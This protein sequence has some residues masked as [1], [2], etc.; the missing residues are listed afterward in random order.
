MVNG[1]LLL[2]LAGREYFAVFALLA[3]TMK[4]LFILDK[5]ATRNIDRIE[6][7]HDGACIG[8]VYSIRTWLLVICMIA[9]GRFLRRSVLPGEYIGTIYLLVGWGL[10][11]SSRLMWRVWIQGRKE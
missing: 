11:L 8:S 7:M 9:L 1:Y 3:G 4:S 2:S 10:F 6:K 5:V